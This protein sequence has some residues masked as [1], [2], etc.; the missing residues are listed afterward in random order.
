MPPGQQQIMAKLER[1]L[2]RENRFIL[3]LFKCLSRDENRY[4]STSDL[5][6]WLYCYISFMFGFI[7]SKSIHQFKILYTINEL[8]LS[9]LTF[10]YFLQGFFK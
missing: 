3:G 2:N 10:Y 6:S 5:L 8:A 7:E 9:N 4:F 1:V